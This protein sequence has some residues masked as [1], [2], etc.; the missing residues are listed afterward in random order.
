MMQTTARPFI[1]GEM[2]TSSHPLERFLPPLQEGVISSWLEEYLPKGAWVLD[3]LGSTPWL[4]LEAARAGFRVLVASNNPI[5]T[6]LL[7]E[8]ASAPAEREIQ[9]ALVELASSKRLDER[10]EVHVQNL[11]QTEC[12]TCGLVIPAEAFL[13][14]RGETKPY[15]RIYRCPQCG[16]AGEHPASANDENRLTPPGRM[17][18]HKARAIERISEPDSPLRAGAVEALEI[19]QPRAL[20]VISTILNRIEGLNLPEGRRKILWSLTL[21]MLDAGNV[22]WNWPDQRSRPRQLTTPSQFREN[23]L[24]M[25]FERAAKEWPRIE[26]TIPVTRWPAL[27]TNEGGICIFPGRLRSWLP[28]PKTIQPGAV[29]VVAPRPNQAFW[30]LSAVWSGW[31]WGRE[32]VLPLRG[33]LERRRY[34][35]QWHAS[36]LHHT[37]SV[38]RKNIPADTP[39]FMICPEI[40]P[41]FSSAVMAATSAAGY[42]VT[43]QAIRADV[44]TAELV[45]HSGEGTTVTNS[46][47]PEEA[48]QRG[49]AEV[50]QMRNEPTSYLNIHAAALDALARNGGLPFDQPAIAWDTLTRIQNQLGRVFNKS[51]QLIRLGSQAQNNES[52]WWWLTEPVITEEYPLADRV[53][54]EVIRILL[55]RPG[56]SLREADIIICKQFPGWLTPDRGWL[57]ACLE[58][59]GEKGNNGGWKLRE[60]ETPANRRQDILRVGDQLTRLSRKMELTTSGENPWE[61]QD[62]NGQIQ[63]RFFGLASSMIARFVLTEPAEDAYQKVLILPGSRSRLLL[64]KLHQD[65]R[66]QEKVEGWHILKFRHLKALAERTEMTIGLFTSSLET[67]LVSKD[68]EQERMI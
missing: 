14:K 27:P 49:V 25:A 18:L 2:P 22:L 36:A 12:A 4:A 13:W 11:Y 28:L 17:E 48:I 23:N 6:L 15:G 7:E 59:Y 47:F 43:G 31:L 55:R 42:R 61:W 41:G 8:L 46:G 52:G 20:Y 19:V 3:P 54:L 45:L 68:D 1:P 21:S 63:I 38:L 40:V 50:L 30:T 62:Q 16:D 37:L 24:W 58:S 33:A 65:Y 56:I 32:A 34:D 64:H 66:L 35:W 44:E 10:L 51:D 39:V 9:S 5:L 57:E 60:A 67:D 53:E 26:Q 29:I